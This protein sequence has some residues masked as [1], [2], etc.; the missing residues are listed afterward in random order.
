MSNTSSSKS[1][2]PSVASA[3]LG[4]QNQTKNGSYVDHTYHDFSLYLREGGEII[5]HKK[6]ESNFPAKLHG[7]LSDPLYSHVIAW[8]SHGR[9]WR[10]VN[11]ELLLEEVAPL[12]FSQSRFESFTRQLS[13]WGFKRLHRVGPDFGCYYHEKFLRD[14]PRLTI[15]MERMLARQGKRKPCPEMEPNFYLISRL[16]PLPPP[17][18][19]TSGPG[20]VATPSTRA[21]PLP[22]VLAA[23]SPS[24][25]STT[26]PP[27]PSICDPLPSAGGPPLSNFYLIP[28]LRPLPPPPA[29][30]FGPGMVATSS[31]CTD[32]LPV[33]LAA[34]S[35]C[36]AMARTSAPSIYDPLPLAGGPPASWVPVANSSP[37]TPTSS[38]TSFNS[39]Q[40]LAM[41]SV[42][43]SPTSSPASTVVASKQIYA[44]GPTAAPWDQES[45]TSSLATNS[46]ASVWPQPSFHQQEIFTSSVWQKEQA[47]FDVAQESYKGEETFEDDINELLAPFGKTGTTRESIY[48][49]VAFKNTMDMLFE[50]E[51]AFGDNEVDSHF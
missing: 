3:E 7:V 45:L 17:P 2:S 40:D 22:V 24:L 44:Q 47:H 37:S 29:A 25:A 4:K 48:E 42:H 26:C 5:K 43:I 19:A 28:R 34:A 35:P 8:M 30:T 49:E 21:D 11:K 9:A 18:A 16:R 51:M 6:C 27:V 50:K 46:K 15:L 31:L 36:L 10:I 1:K 39:V 13:S 23:G 12:I 38:V 20:T 41:P 33:V 32:P 14:L